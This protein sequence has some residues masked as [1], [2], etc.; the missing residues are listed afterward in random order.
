MIF[1]VEKVD[2]DRNVIF[3]NMEKYLVL[4]EAPVSEGATQAVLELVHKTLPGKPVK[5]VHLS[6]FHK[7]HVA[8]LGKLVDAG[9]TIICTPTMEKPIRQLLKDRQPAFLFFLW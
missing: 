6:H 2:G 5:Y 9:A 8:G 3:I 4:T 1:L 7:D